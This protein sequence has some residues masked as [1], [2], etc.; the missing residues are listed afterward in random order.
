MDVVPARRDDR[1]VGWRVAADVVLVV[2]LSFVGFV[3]LGGLLVWRRRSV[4]RLHLPAVAYGAL[5]TLVGFTCPLTPAE[6][7]LRQQ[8]GSAG[9]EG[10][11]VEHYVVPV[12]YPGEFTTSVKVAAGVLIVVVNASVY[13]AAAQWARRPERSRVRL[14]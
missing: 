11:F 10:G 6:K 7:W 8:A 14:S 1:G 12:L 5:V 9:Y 2:H 3:L 13:A 4:A